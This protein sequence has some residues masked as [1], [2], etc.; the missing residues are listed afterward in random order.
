[1]IKFKTSTHFYQCKGEKAE[2]KHEATLREARKEYLYPSITTIDKAEFVNEFLNQ[3]KMNELVIAASENFKMPHEEPEDYANRIYNLSLEK[4]R[5]AAAFGTELHDAIEHYPQMPLDPKLGEFLKP[6]GAWYDDFFSERI[7]QEKIVFDHA[8]G[9]A[10]RTD[11][12]GRTKKGGYK[13]VVDWKSQNVK[14]DKKGRKVPAFYDS[15]LRQ[16]AFYSI[17]EGKNDGTF[18]D[19][20]PECISVVVDS[21]EPCDPFVK[22][23]DRAMVV[24]AY[25]D[26]II[27]AYRYFKSRAF[28]PQPDGAFFVEPTVQR[29]VSW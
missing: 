24:S 13:C 8:L 17:C 7:S 25:E 23:W 18:P 12:I 14:K 29:P 15:W 11:F 20:F 4:S 26:V 9:V 19:A 22:I 27:A 3:W 16:L 28:W 6:F 2:P 1:M 5:T 21:N 10:G